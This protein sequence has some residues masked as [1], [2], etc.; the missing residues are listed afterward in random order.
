MEANIANAATGTSCQKEMSAKPERTFMN[1]SR[2]SQRHRRCHPARAALAEIPP[3]SRLVLPRLALRP[4]RAPVRPPEIGR[5][6]GRESVE[7]P[8]GERGSTKYKLGLAY[9]R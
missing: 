4:M 2:F 3:R 7:I 9:R 6:S 8:G 5:A 1:R